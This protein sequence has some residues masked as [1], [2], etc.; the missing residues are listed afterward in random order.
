[1]FV[2]PPVYKSKQGSLV[3]RLGVSASNILALEWGGRGRIDIYA[4]VTWSILNPE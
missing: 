3:I 4:R 1:M 2:H